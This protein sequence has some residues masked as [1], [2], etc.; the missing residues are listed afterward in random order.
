MQGIASYAKHAVCAKVGIK[1]ARKGQAEMLPG[2]LPMFLRRV[3]SLGSGGE[4]QPANW[5]TANPALQMGEQVLC[6]HTR[7]VQVYPAPATHFSEDDQSQG[8]WAP[9]FAGR[10]K[11]PP[12]GNSNP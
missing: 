7:E 1:G 4:R 8:Q 11:H 10:S 12:D 2:A 9:A 5:R 6:V 3:R